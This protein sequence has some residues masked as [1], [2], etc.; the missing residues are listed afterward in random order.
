MVGLLFILVHE[1]IV[2]FLLV[3]SLVR[4]RI[5]SSPVEV[6]VLLV[7]IRVLILLS[8]L[9]WP[10]HIMSL[11]W[12]PDATARLLLNLNLLVHTIRS[13]STSS[14]E[15]HAV[16]ILWW[17]ITSRSLRENT[18][19]GPILRRILVSFSSG[20]SWV[21]RLSVCCHLFGAPSLIRGQTRVVIL[22]TLWLVATLRA[23]KLWSPIGRGLVDTVVL[24]RNPWWRIWRMLW[25]RE[26]NWVIQ[27][28]IST[29]KCFLLIHDSLLNLIIKGS[30]HILS[31]F[32]S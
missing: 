17:P 3:S 24:F 21:I 16:S 27:S 31:A 22:E 12:R 13:Y 8:Y 14:I 26:M 28:A 4:I 30:E 19:R 10:L 29:S 5:L 1:I 6:D 20:A 15:V 11:M 32:R 23:G 2:L 18:D 9:Y 25:L 7:F